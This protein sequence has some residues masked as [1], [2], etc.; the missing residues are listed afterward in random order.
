MK[1]SVK[2]ADFLV[3]GGGVAGLRAAI[4]LASKGTVIVLTK[5]KPT[6]STTGYAQGG[7]AV[8]LS[9]ED[10]VGIH[11]DDTIKAGA[12]LCN[13]NAVKIMVEEGPEYIRE[14]ISWGA[15]FDKDGTKLSFTREAAHSKK[16]IL[17][18][19][20]DSTGKEIERVLIKK[21][22]SC[23]LISRYDFAFTLDLLKAGNRCIGASVLR[24][25]SVINIY[26]KAV[27]LATGGAG[28]VYSK[29]T[30][31]VIATGDGIAIA[32]RAGALIRD[33]EFVQFHPTTLYS[34]GAPQFLLSEAM[35][36][37][38]AVL[39][40]VHR[41]RFMH[42]YHEMAELASR[43]T[44]TRAIV[45]EMV[46]TH[47]RHVFLDLTHLDK[48]FAKNRF[49]QIYSTCL[50]Y[51]IDITE[52]L[53]PVSPAAHYMMGG[54]GTNIDGETSIDGLFAAGEVASTGVHGANRLASNS[55]LEG[56]V[57]GARVGKRAA[58]YAGASSE[59]TVAKPDVSPDTDSESTF[60]TEKVRSSLRQIM[61]NKAGII[62]CQKSLDAAKA[63]ID[64][65]DFICKSPGRNRRDYELR[66][67]MTVALLITNSAR[68]RRGS[69]GAHYRSDKKDLGDNW[70][71]HSTCE[72]GKEPVLE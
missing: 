70:Q 37:E 41:Q 14:L 45:S 39:K 69:V 68:V 33:M 12:G 35:R 60:D 46:K 25:G 66:N 4:E 42:E 38:G 3:I 32:Y 67:M 19:H 27:I 43:D 6:E 64:R 57:F 31:P 15:E 40:N 49:P 11:Y 1:P 24:A 29:T 63:W 58:I 7:I 54:V 52:D 61:W 22:Q 5:D 30:N 23:P 20:G 28:Q 26:A 48:T 65:K 71:H 17:H 21:A 10:E 72:K 2:S 16:R 50:Q 8:A 36:G 47:S 18:A 53:I 9:D 59:V 55:L 34:R 56:L 13:E 51:D 62:R 44:V